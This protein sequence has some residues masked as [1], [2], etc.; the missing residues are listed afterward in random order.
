M[1]T[2]LQ[3]AAIFP[4]NDIPQGINIADYGV[5]NFYLRVSEI[6]PG[7]YRVDE[8]KQKNI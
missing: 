3:D 8:N 4:E 5:G 7:L 6:I 1:I 2:Y